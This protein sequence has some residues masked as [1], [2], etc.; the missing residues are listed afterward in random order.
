MKSL[1]QLKFLL[2]LFITSSF[3][4]G[5]CTPE[6][7]DAANYCQNADCND[8]N[9]I[10]N[11]RAV[12]IYEALGY[13][14]C[15][16]CD[17]GRT[18][19]SCQTYMY[20]N[21]F[22]KDYTSTSSV[23]DSLRID[24]QPGSDVNVTEMAITL[25]SPTLGELVVDGTLVDRSNSAGLLYYTEF[26]NGNDPNLYKDEYL[27]IIHIHAQSVGGVDIGGDN[28]YIMI[29]WEQYHQFV[30]TA[31]GVGNTGER[32]TTARFFVTIDGTTVAGTLN[33]KM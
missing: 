16:A 22:R 33:R 25:Y 12:E 29:T 17:N 11:S 21:F 30:K 13:Q 24:P 9:A 7:Q 5:G 23:L 31:V 1:T 18:G 32:P 14:A 26:F 3:F 6:D 20:N 27:P 2:G 4:I 19:T 28:D 15:C 10:A 8:D